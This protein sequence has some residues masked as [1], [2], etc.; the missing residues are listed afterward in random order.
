MSASKEE[1]KKKL[2]GK[3]ATSPATI[4]ESE[5]MDTDDLDFTF[6]AVKTD[7]K[8]GGKRDKKRE[9]DVKA[10]KK[11]EAF[12]D[13]LTTLEVENPEKAKELKQQKAIEASLLRV[14]GVTVKDNISMLKKAVKKSEKS[15]QKSNKEWKR[16]QTTIDNAIKEKR[17]K[18]QENL[19]SRAK[20]TKKAIKKRNRPG[21]EA[22]TSFLN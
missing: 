4:H 5:P 11:A 22:A 18:K 10:L 19:D 8:K 7:E 14:Q 6:G 20:N 16:R 13:Y 12:R 2:K 1:A 9:S 3:P 21:F 17:Q 15:K